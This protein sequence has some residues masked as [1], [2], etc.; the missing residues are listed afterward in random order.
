MYIWFEMHALRPTTWNFIIYTIVLTNATHT[1]F[2]IFICFFSHRMTPE[3]E[4]CLLPVLVGSSIK[5]LIVGRQFT[6][7]TQHFL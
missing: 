2:M 7:M 5:Y 1:P 3:I 6:K 4:Q